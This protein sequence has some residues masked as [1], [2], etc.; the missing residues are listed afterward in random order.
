MK[1]ALIT[2]ITGQDGSYLAELLLKKGYKVI[3]LVSLKHG[4]GEENIKDIKNKLIL[5]AGDLLDK[6]S[7]ERILLK[8]KPA[9]VY[10]LGAITFVPDSWNNISLV[11]DINCV[12]PIRLLEII[13]TKLPKTRF[14]QATSSKIFGFPKKSPQNEDT[15]V[16]PVQPYGSSKAGAHFLVKNYR[17]RF[18]IH[19]ISLIMYNHESERRGSNFVTR[20]ITQGAVKIKLGFA[21]KITLGDIKSEEDWGY[22]PDYVRAMWLALQQKNPQDFIIATG[23]LHTVKDICKIAFSHLGLNY[24]KFVEVDKSFF[25]LYKSKRMMG[26]TSRARRVLGWQPKIKFEKM[27]KKMV[28]YDYQLLKG[29]K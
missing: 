26:D 25:R 27:I 16:N 4:I 13:R 19:A 29:K 8:Y 21:K 20:K 6:K 5:E 7:L 23:K 2:G 28:D 22:A 24:R 14:L 11:F 15:P 9:E 1:K 12:G 17:E 18:G 3:G 10:N